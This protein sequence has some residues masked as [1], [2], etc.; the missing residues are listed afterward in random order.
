LHH[1]KPGTKP[2]AARA[3]NRG[4]SVSSVLTTNA[5]FAGEVQWNVSVIK[6][7]K[8]PEEVE[9][10]TKAENRE[11]MHL[12]QDR[13][14]VTGSPAL[15]DTIKR[16]IRETAVFIGD[17]T[18]VSKCCAR[19]IESQNRCGDRGASELDGM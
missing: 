8:Q 2:G 1:Q 5:S 3:W 10:P 14:N 12:D 4:Q 6:V 19:P 16:K 9:E 18:P 13:Q 11:S 7:L 17:V 15:A